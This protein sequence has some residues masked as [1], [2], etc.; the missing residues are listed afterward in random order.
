MFEAVRHQ[1]LMPEMINAMIK[2]EKRKQD[3]HFFNET[4]YEEEDVE[5]SIKRLGLTED[6]EIKAITAEYEQ[7]SKEFLEQKKLDTE[8]LMAQM[9][10]MKKAHEAKKAELEKQNNPAEVESTSGMMSAGL[11]SGLDAALI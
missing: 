7:K 4:G 1:R 9:A 10:E 2:A 11:G 6:A 8:K 5:P 3:D